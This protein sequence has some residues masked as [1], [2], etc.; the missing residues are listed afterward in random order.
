MT[1]VFQDVFGHRLH[2]P[3][4]RRQHILREHPEISVY[5]KRLPAVFAAPNVVK[6]SRRDAHVYLYYRYEP[7]L[8]GGKYLLGV[9]KIGRDSVVLTAYVTDRIKQGDMLWPKD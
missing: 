7:E 9:A 8:W 3:R 5:L 4:A 1:A 2:L 6:R